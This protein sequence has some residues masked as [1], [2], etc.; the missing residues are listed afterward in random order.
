MTIQKE[1]T[2]EPIIETPVI[3]LDNEELRDFLQANSTNTINAIQEDNFIDGAY[4]VGLTKYDTIALFGQPTRVEADE[5]FGS[6]YLDYNAYFEQWYYDNDDFMLGIVNSINYDFGY[7]SLFS[8]NTSTISVFDVFVGDNIEEAAK[9]I[10]DI[11]FGFTFENDKSVEADEIRGGNHYIFTNEGN[12]TIL[13]LILV[14]DQ[15]DIVRIDLQLN[16]KEV[17]G[18][19]SSDSSGE[20][21]NNN[22][23]SSVGNNTDRANAVSPNAVVN[24]EE[25]ALQYLLDN[26]P[27]TSGFTLQRVSERYFSPGGALY[28]YIVSFNGG[29]TFFVKPTGVILNSSNMQI[30]P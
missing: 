2:I 16:F 17:M 19:I 26:V 27:G 13:N 3:F 6:V 4:I 21:V 1:T 5:R 18:L 15:Y 9:F 29:H 14:A 8:I 11:D 7:V 30:Y 28:A 22:D 25:E 23:S 10:I 24:S 12:I 20:S